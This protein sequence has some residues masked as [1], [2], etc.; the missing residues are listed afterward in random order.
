MYPEISSE[1]S[2]TM[3]P[4]TPFLPHVLDIDVILFSLVI[5]QMRK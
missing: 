2:I 5:F 3:F 4:P 1:Y